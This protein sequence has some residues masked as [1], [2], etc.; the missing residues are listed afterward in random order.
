MSKTRKVRTM[1]HPVWVRKG[2]VQ[3][4]NQKNVVTSEDRKRF[5]AAKADKVGYSVVD[6][7]NRMI[8]WA[9]FLKLFEWA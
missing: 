8:E 4:R 1:P 7:K 6:I 5:Y 3:P 2:A 9:E